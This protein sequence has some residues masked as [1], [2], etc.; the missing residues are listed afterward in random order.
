MIYTVASVGFIGLGLYLIRK[1]RSSKWG[2]CNINKLLEGEVIIV[3]GANSGLGAEAAKDFARRGA[4]VIFACRN[5]SLTKKVIEDIKNSTGNN[6]LYYKHL[7][8]ASLDSVKNF[9]KDV[10]S[11]FPKV[12]TLVCNAGVWFP[13]DR[14]LKS[15]DGFEI[16]TG[17]NHLGHFLLTNLLLPKLI[18]SAPSRVVV[19]SSAL[20]SSGRLDFDKHDHFK[21]GRIPEVDSKSFAPTGYCDSKLMNALFSKELSR[22]L[23]GK[24]VTTVS[25]CPGFCYT[26]LSRN[27]NIPFYKKILFL[28]VAFMFMRTAS[29][30]AQ[31]I[32]HAVVENE[33]NLVSGG[34]Y[35]DCKL[36]T[37]ENGV[38]DGMSSI[39][40]ELWKISEELTGYQ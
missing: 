16:H 39:G 21:L 2:K 29:Q 33:Q 30:G 1:W 17:V 4:T 12:N 25:L 10:A 15:H 37:K 3:T 35:K 5:S 38:L 32:I 6:N 14:A 9:V 19:V 40:L 23:L 31:N 7:D 24:G 36:A 20:Q 34:F 11:S 28:P 26:D 18:E 8:L 13:M 22:R 27:V